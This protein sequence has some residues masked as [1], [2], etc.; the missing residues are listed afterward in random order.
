MTEQDQSC[1]PGKK[2]HWMIEESEEGKVIYAGICKHCDL[3][4][5]SDIN[6]AFLERSK[7]VSITA[8]SEPDGINK[9]YSKTKSP[10]CKHEFGNSQTQ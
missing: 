9:L 7:R 8:V 4:K 5:E 2:H 10:F 1:S 6:K 3:A